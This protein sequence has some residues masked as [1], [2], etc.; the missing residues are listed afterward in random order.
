MTLPEFSF[1]LASGDLP[2]GV[3]DR[4]I[5]G[6][7]F[8]AAETSEGSGI[9][10]LPGWMR[11]QRDGDQ[12]TA[13]QTAT[14]VQAG[15]GKHVPRAFSRDGTTFG[16]LLE[17]AV[18]NLVSV[19][20]DDANFNNYTP[21]G[22]PLI[23]AVVGPDGVTEDYEIEDDDGAS[24]ELIAKALTPGVVALPH[25]LSAW[26]FLQAPTPTSGS[27]LRYADGANDP[28]ID[29]TVVETEWTFSDVTVADIDDGSVEITPRHTTAADTGAC[30]WYGV[31]LEQRS[32]PTSYHTSAKVVDELEAV[33][34]L[35]APDGY[36]D[37]TMRF[38]PHYANDEPN[39]DHNLLYI[40]DDNRVFYRASDDNIVFRINADDVVSGALTFSRHQELTVQFIHSAV[41]RRLIVTG[42]TTGDGTTDGTLQEAFEVLPTY[43]KVMGGASGSEEGADLLAMSLGLTT[44]KAL[45]DARI[46]AQMAGRPNL[47][48]FRKLICAL[49]I[50]PGYFFDVCKAVIAALE[51]ETAVGFQ[52]DL[53]GAVVGLTREGFTDDRYRVFLEIQTELLLAS[54]RGDAEWTGTNEN[55]LRIV[56]K[57]IGVGGTISL[58]NVP[59]YSFTLSVPTLTLSEA[60]LLLRFIRTALYAAV[61]GVVT[62]SLEAGKWASDA[63]AVGSPGKWASDSVVVAGA[64]SWDTVLGTS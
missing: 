6:E 56:R 20:Q 12:G 46:L 24:V 48:D 17:P 45:A 30:R 44:F 9:I 53:I 7:D 49:A 25:T 42:A 63:V 31:Q 51:I 43:M 32:Y 59:P 2:P 8:E 54:M 41:R 35:V 47:R 64:S 37:V 1:G 23:N 58:Q 61:T 50:Q 33:A 3:V 55:I 38:R 11:L 52:L 16:L 29:L 40:D 13:Q 27:R 5:I 60:P 26:H 22:T 36:L 15:Y 19:S 28:T 4:G 57:F 18:D 62:F 34:A 39:G 14:T 10:R 21:T